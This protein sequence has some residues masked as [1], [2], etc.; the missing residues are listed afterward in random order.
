MG[1][2]EDNRERSKLT[3]LFICWKPQGPQ[4]RRRKRAKSRGAPRTGCVCRWA[5]HPLCLW[6]VPTRQGSRPGLYVHSLVPSRPSFTLRICP[7]GHT[8]QDPMAQR[9]QG[10]RK[11]CCPGPMWS[12]KGCQGFLAMVLCW[13]WQSEGQSK[14]VSQMQVQVKKGTKQT[15][16]I[17]SRCC[18]EILLCS[19][20][21]YI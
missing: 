1:P 14:R 11:C 3:L 15:K 4:E 10:P 5:G 19:T 6:K 8:C 13:P 16:R 20:G 9:L 17:L 18:N 21:N 2:G 7:M 12:R